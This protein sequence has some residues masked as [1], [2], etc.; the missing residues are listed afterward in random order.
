MSGIAVDKRLDGNLLFK[1]FGA[2][3]KLYRACVVYVSIGVLDLFGLG[4][5]LTVGSALGSLGKSALLLGRCSFIIL[6]QEVASRQAPHK[7]AYQQCNHEQIANDFLH[8]N[9]TVKF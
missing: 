5:A 7:S 1:G 8:F 2:H 3:I 4:L 9:L 6:A